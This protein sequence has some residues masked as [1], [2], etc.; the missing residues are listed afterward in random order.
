M[1]LTSSVLVPEF[2]RSE[3]RVLSVTYSG[4]YT[5]IYSLFANI[6]NANSES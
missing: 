5:D 3:F 2:L 6:A 1:Q 4:T